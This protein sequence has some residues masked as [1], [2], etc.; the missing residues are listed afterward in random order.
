MAIKEGSTVLK[1]NI[2]VPLSTGEHL[3]GT[4]LADIPNDSDFYVVL[5]PKYD[6]GFGGMAYEYN[7]LGQ[8]VNAGYYL[9]PRKRL[10]IGNRIFVS[11]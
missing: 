2:T 4:D 11:A 5:D 1:D 8:L 10:T 3:P 6:I 7:S 9:R